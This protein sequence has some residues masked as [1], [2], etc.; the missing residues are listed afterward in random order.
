MSA[1]YGTYPPPASDDC[2]SFTMFHLDNMSSFDLVADANSRTNETGNETGD[3]FLELL[4]SSSEPNYWC[5]LLL[6][7]PVLTVFGNVLVCLSVYN[8][9][10]LHTV[11]NYFIV[12]L[13]VA[14]IMVAILVMP[15]AVYVEV[16][17]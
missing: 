7:F 11:T 4:S 14:D 1:V 9:K 12:A 3:G 15:L 16:S 8:E 5:L 10:A 2:A 6:L 13:A 17:S